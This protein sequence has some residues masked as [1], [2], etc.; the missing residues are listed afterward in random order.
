MVY[1]EAPPLGVA[2]AYHYLLQNNLYYVLDTFVLIVDVGCVIVTG[3]VIN[4]HPL[5]SVTVQ[6]PVP[7]R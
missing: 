4:E 7:A 1:G 5:A 2:V 3:E 6:V